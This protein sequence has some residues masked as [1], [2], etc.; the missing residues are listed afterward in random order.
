MTKSKTGTSPTASFDPTLLAAGAADAADA[1]AKAGERAAFLVDAWVEAKNAVAVAAVANDE[2]VKGPAR[3]AARRGLNV[4]KARGVRLPERTHVARTMGD[5]VEGYEAW[6]V[7]PDASGTSILI[8][9]GRRQSGRYRMA[10]F[11]VRDGVGLLE[12][13]PLEMSRS[14]L[15]GSFDEGARRLG[16][17]PVSVPVDWARARVTAAKL[18]NA[19][20]GAILPL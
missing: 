1:V 13:R 8:I 5:D 12:V 3:K 17:P 20:S 16:Y 18:E 19:K 4:L 14:Q 6:L 7:P 2:S 15:K 9:A 10:Q 11:V